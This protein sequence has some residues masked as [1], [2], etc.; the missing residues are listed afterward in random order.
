MNATPQDLT[1]QLPVAGSPLALH[2]F[3]VGYEPIREN[4]SLRDGSSTRYLLE[5]V[6]AAA[7]EYADGWVLLDGGFNLD[8]VRSPQRRS[9]ELSYESYTPVVAPGDALRA[10]VARA[11]LDWADLAACAVSHAHFDHTGA[12]PTLP[13]AAVVVVQRREWQWVAGGAGYHEFVLPDDLLDAARRVRLVD[14]DALL[15]PGLTALSTYGHTPGHQSFRV[16]LPGRSIV[17]ACDAADLDANITTRTPC[18]W[19][20]TEEGA[21]QAQASIDRLA[22]LRASGVEVW[23]GHDPDWAPWAAAMRGESV[24]IRG[25]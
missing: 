13:D 4:I 9:A 2:A 3:V 5:P 10:G 17:L 20:P 15:A 24:V 21:A 23:P 14:D 22:D 25:V 6:T 18:G 11:G 1:G 8:A 7:V 16:D 12:V 19:T